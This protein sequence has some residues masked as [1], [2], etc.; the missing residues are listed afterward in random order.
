MTMFP[1][2]LLTQAEWFPVD[3]DIR[4]REVHFV[5]LPEPVIE[6]ASF[7]DNRLDFDRKEVRVVPFESLHG[8]PT[9]QPAWLWH[10][11]FCGST[12]LA[13]MLHVSPFNISL[14][15]PM[16][17]R[18]LSDEVDSGRDISEALAI[19]LPLLA[20]P[21]HA[22]SSVLIK[23]THAA[24]NIA[25]RVMR[26]AEGSAIILTSSLEDFLISHL[27]KT[28][29]TL[30]KVPVL[31]E[32]ALAAGRLIDRLPARAFD[33]PGTLAAITLQWAAQR[34]LITELQV[35]LGAKRVRIVDWKGL[36]DD[37]SAGARA[38]S[39]LLGLFH[40]PE[41]ALAANVQVHAGRHSKVTGRQF[42]VHSRRAEASTLADR[43][44]TQLRDA[45]LWAEDVLFPV[46]SRA[47][48][49]P[50]VSLRGAI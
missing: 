6:S 15:E 46:M 8:L 19:V 29:E 26:A 17:L 37:L 41:D 34:E 50:S 18:R 43:F 12:L 5:H 36:Q 9:G 22:G 1:Q 49:D 21:W 10:T 28:P 3:V 40:I 35:S 42:D 30:S 7:L 48:I 32:R 16:V 13:R 27:K 25:E 4:S 39:Q 2:A 23:P 20:R 44:S 14:R 38:C 45:M 47:A 11:S 31:T 33:P 24:L